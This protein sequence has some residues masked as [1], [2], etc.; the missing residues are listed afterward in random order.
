MRELL[1]T[2]PIYIALLAALLNLVRRQWSLNLIALV[3]QFIFII[4]S[5]LKLFP[6]QIALIQPFSGIMVSLMLFLTLNQVGGM[7][8][9]LKKQ[10]ADQVNIQADRNVRYD[11]LANLMSVIQQQ[12]ISKLGFVTQSN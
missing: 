5:L 12:G 11:I 3:F 1:N 2:L 8:L 6:I 9:E 4:P 7:V 10:G